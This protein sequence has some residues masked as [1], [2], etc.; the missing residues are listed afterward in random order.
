MLQEKS[1]YRL[2][3]NS[4]HGMFANLLGTLVEIYHSEL[5]EQIPVVAWDESSCYYDTNFGSNVWN[6]FFE[7]V[8]E[9]S[10][11]DVLNFGN[12]TEVISRGT[13]EIELQPGQD[14]FG[15][16]HNVWEKHVRL[17]RGLLTK[18]EKVESEL[19]KS[20]PVLGV[21]IRSTD[22]KI[23]KDS[24]QNNLLFA[25]VKPFFKEAY[26]Y[27]RIHPGALVFV[28]SDSFQ[29]I[30]AMKSEFGSRIITYDALRSHDDTSI[31]GSL[32]GGIPGSGYRKGEDVIVE[33]LLLSRCDYLVHGPSGVANGAKVINLNLVSKSK[34]ITRSVP[35]LDKIKFYFKD[36]RK[37]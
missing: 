16:L 14:K 25:G 9:A 37:Y 8:S 11:S 5:Y 34:Q 24:K 31:H 33:C 29:N 17:K 32:D 22:R 23:D 35:L 21:H 15:I 7:P 13:R 1:L 2:I 36:A 19:F 27:L 12:Y 30:D 6:Y 28:A 26:K 20:R 3:R 10:I 4:K 18:V